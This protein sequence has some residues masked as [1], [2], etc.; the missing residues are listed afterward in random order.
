YQDQVS[1]SC[2]GTPCLVIKDLGLQISPLADGEG[3]KLS[4]EQLEQLKGIDVAITTEVPEKDGANPDASAPLPG[5]KL[6]TS[7]PFVANKEIHTYDL[8]MIYGSPSGQYALL[9]KIEKALLP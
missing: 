9:E 6:W 4:A 8:E 3:S 7:L 1:V 2:Y 5:N